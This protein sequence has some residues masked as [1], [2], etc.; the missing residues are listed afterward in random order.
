MHP[1]GTRSI[2]FS[3]CRRAVGPVALLALALTIAG[4]DSS[5]GPVDDTFLFQGEVGF[6]TR[7]IHE[8]VS[9][10]DGIARF[11]VVDLRPKLIDVTLGLR[12]VIGVGIGRPNNEGECLTSFTT[13]AQEGSVFSIGLDKNITYCVLLFDPG[14]LPEDASIEYLVS[15]GPG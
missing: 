13:N 14:S 4:C 9:M 12:L 2:R 8:L 1:F 3:S 7:S 15:V 6:G 5:S 10:D 11:E